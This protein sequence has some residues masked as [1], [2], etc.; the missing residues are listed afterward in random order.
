MLQSM[1]DKAKSWVTFIVVGIIAFMMAITGLETLAPNPNNP[2]VASV[3]GKDITR[4]ELAQAVD[5]QRRMLVQQMGAQFDPAML[6]DELLQ[7]SVLNSLIDRQLLLSSAEDQKMGVGN[8]QIDQIILS[9]PQFQQNG[10]FDKDRYQMMVRSYGMSPLQFRDVL[11]YETLLQQV[12][13]GIVNTEFVTQKELMRLQSLEGQTRDLSWVI[14]SAEAVRNSISPSE[15]NIQSYYETNQS[16]FMTPE[17]VVVDYVVLNK[18]DLASNIEVSDDDIAAEYEFRIEQLKQQSGNNPHVSVILIQTGDSRSFDE[19]TA[20]AEE[21]IG[22]LNAGESFEA[23]AK[24]YSDD[25]M[26]AEKG[27]DL[28]AVAPGFLGD[29]FDEAVAELSVGDVSAPIETDYG[30]Q[31]LTVTSKDDVNVPTLASMRS[32]IEASLKQ[33]EV[34]S[35]YLEQVRELADISFEASDLAQPAEQLGLSITTSEAFGKSGSD[36]GIATDPRV[37]AAAFSEDVLSLGANSELIELTPEQSLVLRVKEHRKPEL[38]P[39]DAVRENIVV[40][41]KRE[42]AARELAARSE[43]VLKGLQDGAMLNVV[44]A[45]RELEVT[46]SEKATRNQAGVP[47][48]LLQAAF[49]MPHPGDNVSYDTVELANGDYAVISL[50]AIYPG[51]VVGD[52]Q[53]LKGLGQFIAAGNGQVMFEEYLSSLKARGKVDILINDE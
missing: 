8:A 42:D 34:D 43:A 6:D 36:A 53:Q 4:A 11:R 30:L 38:I 2:E 18:K 22:K 5:Q 26:T 33:S 27:G 29:E 48:Q 15:E 23:L 47:A 37:P 44:A 19:A 32:E 3:N 41:L 45:E 28:G 39:L 20:R 31:I 14:L 35:L 51:E 50:S 25:P 12:R 1:R 24:T 40:A 49:K 16:Q 46:T 52:S 9:M 13:S 10:R 7:S 21:V 17:Q